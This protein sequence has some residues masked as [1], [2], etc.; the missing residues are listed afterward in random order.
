M[1]FGKPWIPCIQRGVVP[2]QGTLRGWRVHCWQ[3]I[4]LGEEAPVATGGG[5][6]I[7][8]LQ[9]W[10]R[11]ERGNLWC[12]A[13]P[14][15]GISL[16]TWLLGVFF[17]NPQ[18]TQVTDRVLGPQAHSVQLLTFCYGCSGSCKSAELSSPSSLVGCDDAMSRL[19]KH[20]I[21]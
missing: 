21:A 10:R 9:G 6:V 7:P 3:V 13:C 14:T 15:C 2:G 18:V 8:E 20:L 5:R 19:L 1:E 12:R 17:S 16:L 4:Y 11:Q